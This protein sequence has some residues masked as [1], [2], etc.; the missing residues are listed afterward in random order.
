MPW[1]STP[2]LPADECGARKRL[3]EPVQLQEDERPREAGRVESGRGDEGVGVPGLLE[4][5]RVQDEPGVA[6][7]RRLLAF[8]PARARRRSPGSGPDEAW[9]LR[10]DVLD[11]PDQ[12]GPTTISSYIRILLR[13]AVLR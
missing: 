9:Q 5:E 13:M 12:D 11:G 10:Q 2:P 8:D 4:V 6:A 1:L 7:Q 3:G